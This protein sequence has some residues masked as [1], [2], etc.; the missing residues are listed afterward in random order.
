M[1]QSFESTSDPKEGPARLAALRARMAEAGLAGFIVPRADVHQ[2][3]YVAPHDERLQWLTGFTGSAGFCIVLPGVAGVFVDG[4]YR[5]QIKAQVDLASFTPVPWPE[6]K[7]GPWICENLSAGIVG[8]DPW[9][10]SAREIDEIAQGL[11]A[12]GVRLEPSANLVDAV[13]ADQPAP[14][15]GNVIVQPQE[16]AGEASLDKRARL[17][18]GLAKAEISAVVLT[19]PDSISWLLNI[20]GS[21]VARNPVVHAFAILH[22]DATVDLF[23]DPAKIDDTVRAHLGAAVRLAVPEAFAAALEGLAGRVQVDRATAPLAVSQ[24]LRA[25]GA[26]VVWGDDPCILPKACKNPVEIAGAAEAHLRDGAAMVEFLAWFDLTAPG[27][28][29]TEMDVVTALEG[30][31]RATGALREISFDTIC[32]AGPNGAVIHYRVTKATNRGIEAGEIVVID[33][34]GQYADG[35]TDV[36]RTVAVG[37]VDRDA[38]AAFTRVLQGMIALSRL[39]WP[40]GLAGAHIDALARAPL[41]LAGQDYNHGTGHGVGSYLSVHEGPARIS[42][43]SDVP[44]RPGMILSNEPGYYREGA[45]GIRIENLVVVEPAPDLPEGDPDRPMLRFRTLTFVPIDRRLIDVAALTPAERDW[46]DRYHA[47]VLDRIGP[48]VPAEARAWLA[49]ATA[50]LEVTAAETA[51]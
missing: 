49:A 8:F 21:D 38:R 41:W 37:P 14:P 32:G 25:A 3:E 24:I 39:R 27:G 2:G 22:A 4:R 28:G 50:P 15:Q 17:A 26:E 5:T 33:S 6:T 31:R 48:R 16:R 19:L 35:T 42:R 43:L 11:G 29:L 44:L 13:W 18:A 30:Y 10:H 23:L 20:R 36:T 51:S 34:G 46:L 7:P 47:E 9:L 12:S 1:F 45:F 40:L